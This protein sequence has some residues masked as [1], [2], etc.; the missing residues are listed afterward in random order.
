MSDTGADAPP[1]TAPASRREILS[2]ALF[3]FANSS[4]TTLIVTIG[5]SMYFAKTVVASENSELLWGASNF[6][7]E[8]LVV[9]TA[10]IV[11]AIADFS[12]RKKPF[13]LLTWLGCVGGTACLG[14]VGPGDIALGMTLFVVSNILYSSGENLIAAFLPEITTPE[15][16]GR[17]SGYGW[18]LGYFGGLVSIAFCFPFITRYTQYGDT[19]AMRLS[20]TVVAAFF[21]LGGLP[22]FVFLRERARRRPLPAGENY[23]SLGFRRVRETLSRVLRYRQLFLFLIVFGIY[24]CGVQIVIKFASIYAVEIGIA[25][26]A[27]LVFFLVVQI[28]AGV[29]AFAFGFLQDYASSRTA[30]ILSLVL[31]LIVCIVAYMTTSTAVFYAVG[32]LAGLAMGAAQSGGRALVGTFSPPERTGEFFG[33]WGLFWKLSAGVGPLSFGVVERFLGMRTA[34]LLTGLFFVVGIV[35]MLF[36]NEAEGR[37][38][39]RAGSGKPSGPPGVGA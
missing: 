10:P 13:L 15:R 35:G 29:G 8:G 6:I 18:A 21:L 22:T 31:W 11:G 1:T 12:G 26:D 14:L 28:S 30:I 32:N 2:W 23:V 25:G 7:S 19:T 39:A 9:L 33:F 24:N 4:Y 38:E 5:Y 17:V 34:I 3:D 16:M 37:A 27:M 20:F 36:I